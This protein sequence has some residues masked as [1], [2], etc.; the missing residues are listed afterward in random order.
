[1]TAM[2][3]ATVVLLSLALAACSAGRATPASGPSPCRATEILGEG[4]PVPATCEFRLLSGGVM[5]LGQLKG[6]PFL[7][8]F[9]ASWCP[10]CVEEMPA[11][12]QAHGRLGSRVAIV[13]ADLL[14]V[15]G[16]TESAARTFAGKTGATYT[17]IEDQD[18]LL[19]AHFSAVTLPPTT[20][21]VDADGI[22]R[23]RQFGQ[24]DLRTTLDLTR[25][26][27]GVT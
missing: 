25:R 18:G 14:G 15:E 20:I 19:F 12:Q 23:H 7:L 13:G 10:N 11:L 2:R 24:L 17:M 5:T 8:N 3:R 26:Y 9:W 4:Q 22:V 16:E 1:M 21:W 6:K 27:L